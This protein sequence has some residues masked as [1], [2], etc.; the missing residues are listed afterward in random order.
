MAMLSAD[1]STVEDFR[2]ENYLLAGADL[3][4][5]EQLEHKLAH[6]DATRPTLFLAE[7]VLVYLTADESAA[8]LRRVCER[9]E[10]AALLLYEQVNSCSE[11]SEN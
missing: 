3:R 8:L 5:H 9:F 7:C 4:T 6:L 11:E 2:H 1:G 10:N